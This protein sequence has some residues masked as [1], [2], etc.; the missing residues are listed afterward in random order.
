MPYNFENLKIS[1]NHLRD[2][3][4]DCKYIIK[5]LDIESL[6]QKGSSQWK[7]ENNYSL[8]LKTE[9]MDVLINEND[10]F[11]LSLNEDKKDTMLTSKE[12]HIKSLSA[13]IKFISNMESHKDFLNFDN[14]PLL[15]VEK[16][17]YQKALD[18]Y[19]KIF[20]HNLF[21]FEN[22]DPYIQISLSESGIGFTLTS[23][24]QEEKISFNFTNRAP[25]NKISLNSFSINNVAICIS[26]KKTYLGMKL[27][28]LI[29]YCLTT[30]FLYSDTRTLGFNS[31]NEDIAMLKDSFYGFN[32]YYQKINI[33]F[34][35]NGKNQKV[36]V[37]NP[38]LKYDKEMFELINLTKPADY[39]KF[40]N[41]DYKLTNTQR[42][43]L[44]L[45]YLVKDKL[46]NKLPLDELFGHYR[47]KLDSTQEFY[48]VKTTDV[49]DLLKNNYLK[50]FGIKY[51]A[52]LR[53]NRI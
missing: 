26:S 8:Y 45:E 42:E 37:D 51:N 50:T 21:D 11:Y 7:I 43:C 52:E 47:E 39:L 33:T 13:F 46:H 12:H 15:D 6:N 32:S 49:M 48:T 31:K 28:N 25:N 27:P 2:S 16:E 9:K 44:E 29:D 41:N 17:R 5:D 18:K 35:N 53:K 38:E 10:Y 22:F 23:F 24:I 14:Y 20:N 40:F 30:S 4:V 3:L 1:L 36:I 19:K 34:I